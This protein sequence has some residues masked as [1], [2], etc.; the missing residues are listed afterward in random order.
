MTNNA[1]VLTRGLSKLM[2]MN[3]G[4]IFLPQGRRERMRMLSGQLKDSVAP[5]FNLGIPMGKVVAIDSPL[6]RG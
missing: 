2:A 3:P 6:E 1:T 4:Q 5:G